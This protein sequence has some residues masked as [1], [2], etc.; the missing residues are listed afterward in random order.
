V[1]GTGLWGAW[2]LFAMVSDYFGP[3]A[4]GRANGFLQAVGF[5]G[6]I[7]SVLALGWIT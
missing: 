3:E 6:I 7:L 1:L 5:V 4:R 2:T